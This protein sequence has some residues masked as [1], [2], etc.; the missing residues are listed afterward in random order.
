MT[1]VP[2]DRTLPIPAYYQIALDLRRRIGAGEWSDTMRIPAEAALSAEYEVSRMTIRQALSQLE[3]DGL[4][5]RRR[6]T[7]TFIN[8]KP[9]ETAGTI[10]PPMNFVDS[11]RALGHTPV[12]HYRKIAIIPVPSSDAARALQIGEHDNVAYFERIIETGGRPVALTLWMVSEAICPGLLDQPLLDDSLHT[13]I[14]ARYGFKMT[15]VERWVEAIRATDEHATLLRIASGSPL[16]LMTSTYIDDQGRPV[17]YALTHIIGDAM[18]LH[19]QTS[20]DGSGATRTSY[21]PARGIEAGT[22]DLLLA[23]EALIRS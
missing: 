12:V 21:G 6:P 15:R 18:R 9:I 4:L 11:L 1:V 17:S 2:V 14:S 13:T 22:D 23:G 16:L 7:G 10:S 5:V 20:T 3:K 19:I 8:A